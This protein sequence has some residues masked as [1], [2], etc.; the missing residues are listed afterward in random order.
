MIHKL[1][2]KD[3]FINVTASVPTLEI[4][5]LTNHRDMA[6]KARYRTIRPFSTVSY[7]AIP[8]GIRIYRSAI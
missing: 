7:M 2:I 5:T 6:I 4:M 3:G 1:F 8:L